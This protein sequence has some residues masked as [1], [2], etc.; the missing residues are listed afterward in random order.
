MMKH[1][2]DACTPRDGRT[3]RVHPGVVQGIQDNLQE[4]LG[5]RHG[6]PCIPRRGFLFPLSGKQWLGRA[7]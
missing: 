2:D 5:L 1:E 7:S 4:L 6:E 3:Q